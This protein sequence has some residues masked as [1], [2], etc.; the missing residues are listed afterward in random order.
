MIAPRLIVAA[1]NK[2]VQIG[3]GQ[4]DAPTATASVWTYYVSPLVYTKF[5]NRQ[6][7]FEM[8]PIN[9]FIP[10]GAT[11]SPASKEVFTWS[12]ASKTITVTAQNGSKRY[13][14]FRL[15]ISNAQTP[16]DS[17]NLVIFGDQAMQ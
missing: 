12:G 5:Q 11:I 10:A 4:F 7:Y 8:I 17:T 2:G 15:E 13:Y 3:S 9:M 16:N 14:T 6:V 1:T